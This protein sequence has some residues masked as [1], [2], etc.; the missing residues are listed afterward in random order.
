MSAQI[1]FYKHL[2]NPIMRG[3]LRAPIH[4]VV[5]SNIAILHFKGRQTRRWVNTCPS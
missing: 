2:L 3:L 5:S 1:F 4:G